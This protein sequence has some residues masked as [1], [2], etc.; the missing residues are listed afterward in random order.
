MLDKNNKSTLE[1]ACIE[2]LT[3]PDL[4]DIENFDRHMARI[5]GVG[6]YMKREGAVYHGISLLF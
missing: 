4:F 6:L 5:D 2:F 1:D 3:K